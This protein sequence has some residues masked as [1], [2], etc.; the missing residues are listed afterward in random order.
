MS[1]LEILEMADHGTRQM[2]RPGASTRGAD[3]ML[4]V[5]FS[6]SMLQ[7]SFRNFFFGSFVE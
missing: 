4:A 3:E 5:S 6:A 7:F 1:T 2:L